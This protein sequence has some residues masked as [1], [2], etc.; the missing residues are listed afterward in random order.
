LTLRRVDADQAP[1]VPAGGLRLG[2]ALALALQH[3][4]N[5]DQ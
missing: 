3:D 2:D 5:V 4:F 1:L